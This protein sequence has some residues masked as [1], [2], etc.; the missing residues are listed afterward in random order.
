MTHG[1]GNPV[2]GLGQ[3]QKS[4]RGKLRTLKDISLYY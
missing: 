2:P 3:A 1:F 4:G